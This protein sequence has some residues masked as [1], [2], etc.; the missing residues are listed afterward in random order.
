[1]FIKDF[2]FKK[3]DIQILPFPTYFEA[4]D[5]DN[6][7]PLVADLGELDPF[8]VAD[9]LIVAEAGFLSLEPV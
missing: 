3:P 7:E 2:V 9:Y 8:M 6:S 1:V 4:E 5:D